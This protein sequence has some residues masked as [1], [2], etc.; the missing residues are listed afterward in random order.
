MP[1]HTRPRTLSWLGAA[2]M[3]ATFGWS[4]AVVGGQGEAPPAP[5]IGCEGSDAPQADLAEARMELR[6]A[7]RRYLLSAPAWE[8]GDEPLPL[9]V[10]FHGLAEGADV[11]AEMTQLGPLGVE[12]GFVTVFPHG[13]GA[14]EGWD[15][16]PDVAANDDLA[17]VANVLDHV[18][19]ERCVDTA[20]VYAT[21]LS[22][23]AM[24]ASTVACTMADRFAAIAPVAG[25]VLPEPCDP[26]RPV[27]VL[28][29]HGTADPILLFNGGVNLDALNSALG[30]GDDAVTA[31]TV[32]VDLDGEGYPENV[33]R[34]AELDG[35]ADAPQDER[36]GDEVLR[37]IYPCPTGVAVEFLIVEG[38]GHSWP[39]SQ[40]SKAI[41]QIV[42][43][44]TFDV[45]ASR[46]AW[47]FFQRFHLPPL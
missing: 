14:P 16:T 20:R 47:T 1:V 3:I 18:A 30:E 10:D 36:V 38:G 42:G 15:V 44:T 6:G 27:P 31:T 23:G 41:E 4:G 24:M 33:R 39:S 45:D 43:P 40:F 8:V 19:E 13:T 35:C 9:V 11:H 5:S 21:G 29:V 46:E 12:E 7:E 32:A 37:R 28:A 25:V 34:W 17:F 22:M 2:T 26:A